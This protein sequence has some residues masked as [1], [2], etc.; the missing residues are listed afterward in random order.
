VHKGDT[1]IGHKALHT[2]TDW[3]PNFQAVLERPVALAPGLSDHGVPRPCQLGADAQEGVLHGDLEEVADPSRV[4]GDKPLV[5]VP[6]WL[7]LDGHGPIERPAEARRHIRFDRPPTPQGHLELRLGQHKHKVLRRGELGSEHPGL[8]GGMT[9]AQEAGEHQAPRLLLR[10]Q[11]KGMGHRDPEDIDRQSADVVGPESELYR[12]GEVDLD[13]DRAVVRLGR[14][15]LGRPSD[16]AEQDEAKGKPST[17]RQPPS[18]GCAPPQRR[19]G[20]GTGQAPKGRALAFVEEPHLR[21]TRQLQWI[22]R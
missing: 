5:D 8:E 4:Q 20:G 14:R 13:L 3:V 7:A 22:P 12:V 10:S 1:D 11:R 19:R 9:V 21:H 18:P 6:P 15:V 17:A 16:G 2:P